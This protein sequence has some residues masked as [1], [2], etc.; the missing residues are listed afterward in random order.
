M[1]FIR[2]GIDDV[3]VIEVETFACAGELDVDRNQLLPLRRLLP[4][5]TAVVVCSMNDNDSV[6]Q[7]NGLPLGNLYRHRGRI[8]AACLC[9]RINDD[10]FIR[11]GGVSIA[12][13]EDGNDTHK[14]EYWR[15]RTHGSSVA[16]AVVSDTARPRARC[17]RPPPRNAF[18]RHAVGSDALFRYLPSRRT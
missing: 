1:V 10:G 3:Y 12:G 11:R 9:W 16:L 18:P 5:R 2:R 13:R 14:R 17:P 7:A 8:G 6:V 15:D 4:S